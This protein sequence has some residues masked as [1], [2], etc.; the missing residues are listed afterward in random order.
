MSYS[1]GGLIQATDYNG[2]V[3]S[4]PSSTTNQIN[5]IWA[6]GNGNAG[7]GQSALSQVS[8][9]GTVTATQWATAV[10]TLNAIRVHQT[11]SGTGIGAPTAGSLITYLSTF[12]SS[13]S[14]AYT[15][16][17]AAATNGSDITGSA[18]SA[19]TWNT[20]APTTFQITR[21]A[22]FASADQARY[23][24]NAG[25]K[26][27]LTF[28]ATNTLGN[29]KGADWT[30]LLNTKLASMIVGG[31][32]N[33]RTGTGGTA[34]SS[35]TNLGY[36]GC[37][38]SNQGIITLTSASGT[39]DYSSNSVAIGIKT[40]GVQGSNGDVGTVMTFTIDLTDA[41]ADTNTAPPGIPS[42][43]PAGTPPSQGNF[44]DQLNLSIVTNITVR[45]PETTNLTNS[46][47]TVTIA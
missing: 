7:Y 25:G 11:G 10:N 28:S 4:S 18:P 5:T 9:G 32:S 37:T 21:T 15:N 38:T 39:A 6:V 46:W 16:R 33:S 8:V 2:F 30:S 23:F 26:L 40:N 29:S 41:A 3:G 24:F 1:S 19:A 47:G 45:P 22:T 12:S 17:A 13:I 35:N 14:T 42:Y 27:I 43:S 31:A 44:N 20:S 36:W 34:S